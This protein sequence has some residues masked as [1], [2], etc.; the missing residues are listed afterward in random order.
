[1]ITI[2]GK[3]V[4]HQIYNLNQVVI[5]LNTHKLTHPSVITNLNEDGIKI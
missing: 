2:R 1:M 4:P 5:H 3:L